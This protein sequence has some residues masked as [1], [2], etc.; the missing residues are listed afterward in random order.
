MVKPYFILSNIRAGISKLSFASS[1]F[2][3]YSQDDI[4]NFCKSLLPRPQDI[5]RC[6]EP[7]YSELEN[8]RIAEER[9]FGYL[10][11][12]V[13]LFDD[14][15]C[16]VFLK[17]VS[18]TELICSK[19]FVTF[20]GMTCK[21][22]MIP[23]ASTCGVALEISRYFISQKQLENILVNVLNNRSLWNRYDNI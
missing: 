17:F 16:K 8:L 23:K 14:E 22:L 15:Q 13:A 4:L 7:E 5:Y 10:E 9:C 12:I 6:L 1:K 11:N 21:E 18:G 3:D 19:I 2:A 20:N